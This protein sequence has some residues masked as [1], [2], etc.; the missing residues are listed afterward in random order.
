MISNLGTET[1]SIEQFIKSVVVKTFQAFPHQM[2][3]HFL[4]TT[5]FSVFNTRH[6]AKRTLQE[7]KDIFRERSPGNLRLVENA[8]AFFAALRK[9]SAKVHSYVNIKFVNI[10]LCYKLLKSH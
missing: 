8:E 1:P 7:V 2:C 10:F 6:N 9:I 3:W 4:A 5:E